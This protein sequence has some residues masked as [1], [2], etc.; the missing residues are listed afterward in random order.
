L[1]WDRRT[2]G[3]RGSHAPHGTLLR[4]AWAIAH[5]ARD[6]TRTALHP[7]TPGAT[8]PHPSVA[9]KRRAACRD[10]GAAQWH[11]PDPSECSWGA[12]RAEHVP[13]CVEPARPPGAK[14]P[15]KLGRSA[16]A[17]AGGNLDTLR[18]RRRGGITRACRCHA[19][20]A[21]ATGAPRRGRPT[22]PWT[23]DRPSSLCKE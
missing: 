2:G 18:A 23:P 14:R 20:P 6:G 1:L 13:A 4:P 16:D 3:A 7:S 9:R 5:A 21:G 10:R 22:D 11:T 15:V 19:H 17:V 8:H 12:P